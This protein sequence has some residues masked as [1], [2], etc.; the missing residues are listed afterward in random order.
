MH[1]RKTGGGERDG[2]GGYDFQSG[3]IDIRRTHIFMGPIKIGRATR[4]GGGGG[5]RVERIVKIS[6]TH[7]ETPDSRGRAFFT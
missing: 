4:R 7:G 1:G 3:N 6:R 2:G 5:G